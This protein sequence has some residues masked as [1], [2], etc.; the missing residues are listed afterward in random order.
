MAKQG[1]WVAYHPNGFDQGAALFASEV[2]C[3]RHAVEHSMSAAFVDYG[4]DL[5][6]AVAA[7]P[8]RPRRRPT[9]VA[10]KTGRAVIS[11]EP[12]RVIDTTADEIGNGDDD[13]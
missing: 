8:V 11:D 10:D 1:V 7:K 12:E 5:R 6:E 9:L 4:V 13:G 3:L 2:A